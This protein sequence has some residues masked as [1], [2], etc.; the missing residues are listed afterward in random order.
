M[1]TSVSQ[2]ITAKIILIAQEKVVLDV[3]GG[4]PLSKWLAEFRYLF[5]NCKYQTLDPDITTNPSIVGSIYAIP[6]PDNSVDG[7]ICSSVLEH[8]EDPIRAATELYRVLRGGGKLFLYV[9]SI[10]PYHARRG[11]YGDYW[12]FFDDTLLLLFKSFSHIEL[13]KRG[14]YFETL[15][16]F[17]PLQHKL[18]WLLRPVS[19]ALDHLF[20]TESRTTTAGYYLWAVK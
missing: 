3:G 16:L 13:K 11:H 7:I 15:S 17:F 12:R 14:G 19:N 5:T 4:G 9:P 6:L 8:V 18:Q 20:H 10:Y 1:S 2:F